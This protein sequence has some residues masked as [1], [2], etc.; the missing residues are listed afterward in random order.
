MVFTMHKNV[1]YLT[2][3][4]QNGSVIRF[5]ILSRTSV[6]LECQSDTIDIDL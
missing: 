1:A 3:L 4:R 5:R 6:I 2:C